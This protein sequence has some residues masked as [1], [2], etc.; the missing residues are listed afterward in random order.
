MTARISW[1]PAEAAELTGLPYR[2]VMALIHNGGLAA[3]K[4][5]RYWLI[6]D[7]DLR[8]L[9]PSLSAVSDAAP[10]DGEATT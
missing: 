1:T 7:A 8:N 5:S 4:V 6:A 2:A 9:V 10:A 3:T